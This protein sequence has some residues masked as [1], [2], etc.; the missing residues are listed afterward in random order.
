MIT[1]KH[2]LTCATCGRPYRSYRRSQ[3]YCSLQCEHTRAPAVYRYT[4]RD[5]R[6]YV[7]GCADIRN[8][9]RKGIA[10]MNERLRVVFKQHPPAT[11]KF[12]VLERLR[13][14]CSD[15]VL[16]R[17]EQRWID[18]LRTQDPEHGFNVDPAVSIWRP[19]LSATKHG[20]VYYEPE[21]GEYY[22]DFNPAVVGKQR[23]VPEVK[24]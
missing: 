4:C 6:S 11:W 5:G 12:E 18:A 16:R 15:V 14:G 24:P 20:R 8:R 1:L 3:Q 13:P 9:E 2:S 17:A 22:Y 23:P 19:P 21:T 7:G 10:R